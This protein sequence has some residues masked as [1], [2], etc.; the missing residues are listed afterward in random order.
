[1]VGWKYRGTFPCLCKAAAEEEIDPEEIKENDAVAK[2]ISKKYADKRRGA[3]YTDIDVGD[4]VVVAI[5][6]RNKIDPTFS[7]ETYTV[8]TR[9]GA[10]VVICN[11]NG[12]QMTRN[13]Q[14]IKRDSR[15]PIDL[16][17]NVQDDDL[18]NNGITIWNNKFLFG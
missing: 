18:M 2:L 11:D 10:K 14:D 9:E 1:M 4:K 3:R 16:K 12:V 6:Q 15:I 8:L 13:V 5:H 17:D 7:K